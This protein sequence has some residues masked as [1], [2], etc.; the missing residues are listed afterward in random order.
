M[1]KSLSCYSIGYSASQENSSYLT[2]PKGLQPWD[3]RFSQMYCW[4][5]STSGN[6]T[7]CSL[8]NCYQNS[9]RL[10][11]CFLHGQAIHLLGC[12]LKMKRTLQTVT[13]AIYESKQTNTSEDSK[14]RSL[15][16]SLG[17]SVKQHL[18]QRST[19]H[20]FKVFLNIIYYNILPLTHTC[21]LVTQYCAGVG[22]RRSV[23]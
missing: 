13:V 10:C 6:V 17:F 14:L 22:W 8:A 9:D 11:C 21:V 23:W 12:W 4:R 7:S 5:F 20:T 19:E 18:S 2:K 16:Y 1:P 3:L 15:P